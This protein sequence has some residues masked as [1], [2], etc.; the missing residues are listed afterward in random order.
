MSITAKNNTQLRKDDKF[1]W[2]EVEGAWSYICRIH[3][4]DINSTSLLGGN[5]KTSIEIPYITLKFKDSN[6]KPNP[7]KVFI[8]I[9]A[10]GESEVIGRGGLFATGKCFCFKG[11]LYKK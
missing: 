2:S 8:E 6:H 9:L 1:E 10:I 4:A 11:I 3:G 5:Q 7:V